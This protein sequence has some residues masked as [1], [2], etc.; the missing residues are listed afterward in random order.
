[1]AGKVVHFEI[2]AKDTAR[3][4]RFYT[5]LFGWEITDAQMPG[6]EYHLIKAGDG[7]GGGLQPARDGDFRI[8]VYF[9]T[10][11]IEASIRQ[12][13]ELGGKADDK[14]PVPEQ[15]WFAPCTD[16]E[17]NKFALWQDDKTAP[18]ITPQQMAA[19]GSK[20]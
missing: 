9:G 10:D 8:E 1:M 19:A 13:R 5:K 17:G 20:R 14:L 16:T 2:S 12:V 3:A 6:V 11:D 7:P 18:M 4:K 15:G